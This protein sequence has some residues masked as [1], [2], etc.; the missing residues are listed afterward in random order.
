[1]YFIIHNRFITTKKNAKVHVLTSWLTKIEVWLVL[2]VIDF[3]YLIR[4]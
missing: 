1:M 4:T 2:V 3:L